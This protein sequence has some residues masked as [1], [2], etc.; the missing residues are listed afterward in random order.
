MRVVPIHCVRPG[1]RLG[2]TIL[3][4]SG[5]IL[6][7]QGIDLTESLLTRLEGN[8]IYTVY[9]DDGYSNEEIREI[10]QPEVRQKAIQSIREVFT[11]I[12]KMA[13][14]QNSAH[15]ENLKRQL[16]IKSM[17]KYLEA[18][19]GITAH[20]V[21]EI[22][23]NRSLMINL[24]DIK[25]YGNY[26][27]EHSLNVAVLSMIL[28]VEARIPRNQLQSIFTGALMHDVGKVMIPQNICF[29]NGPFT[30]EEEVT[31]RTHPMLGY[32][33]VKEN[34]S[35]DGFSK[36]IILQHHEH[37]DGTGFPRKTSG[38]Y[39]SRASRIVSIAN[40]YVDMTSDTPQK[41]AAPPNEAMEY[42]MASAG[43]EFDFQLIEL[44]VR[45]IVPYP[46]GTLVRV[47]NQWTALVTAVSDNYPLRP[48]LRFL[49]P[50]SGEPGPNEVS[51]MEE[52]NLVITGVVF[53]DP[54][55]KPTSAG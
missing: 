33:Y 52:K 47:N 32:E 36:S 20:L 41:R 54:R 9:V 53:E 39:I 3:S 16:M 11:Q 5:N 8:R 12:G 40:A 49:D 50:Q 15:G 25:T 10:I 29:K 45:K 42:L 30:E 22:L 43:T 51:L 48:K 31:M 7:K 46:P 18:L 4:D 34:R 23:Q 19:K 14:P 1:T 6:L 13:T 28:A 24:V 38:E 55:P 2:K 35:I 21:D 26:I 37:Y 44:F 27:Y 17:T